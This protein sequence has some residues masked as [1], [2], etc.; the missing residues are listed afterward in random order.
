MPDILLKAVPKDLHRRLRERAARNGRSMNREA[1]RLIERGLTQP[2][3][4]GEL[5]PPVNVGFAIDDEFINRAKREGR[6]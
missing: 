6:A 4:I 1:I 5:P 3:R 2:A